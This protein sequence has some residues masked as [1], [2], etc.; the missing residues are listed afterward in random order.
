MSSTLIGVL[1]VLGLS[2]LV[3]PILIW[4]FKTK[5]WFW[6][7]LHMPGFTVRWY[8]PPELTE[9]QMQRAVQL[10]AA[11]LATIW[12]LDAVNTSMNVVSIFVVGGEKWQNAAGVWVGG[13]Q[14]GPVLKVEK[15]LSSLLHEAA[16]WLEEHH[17]GITDY[18]HA[19]WASKKIWTADEGYR[20]ALKAG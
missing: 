16:H 18:E 1:C 17:D 13:E 5:V 8:G 20:A 11:G 3:T 6:H 7:T 2:L 15:S 10:C 14:D 12:D 4:Y 9:A 19:G